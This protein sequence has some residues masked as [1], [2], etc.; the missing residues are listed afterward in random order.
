[1]AQ[2]G[3]I[4]FS[5]HRSIQEQGRAPLLLIHGAGGNRYHWPSQVRRL[6]GRRV[7]SLDLPGHA[8]SS[9]DPQS[10]IM[11]Y[12]QA[13]LAWQRDLGIPTMIPVGH[14]MGGAVALTMALEAPEKVGGLILVGT[15]AR[16]RVHPDLLDLVADPERLDQ[17][18][19]FVAGWAFS[20]HTSGELI[21]LARS[22]MQD[23]TPVALHADYNACNQVDLMERLQEI[24]TPTLVIC[25]EDDRLTPVKYS[26]YLAEQ[27]PDARLTLI[28]KAGHM[29]MLE[30]PEA[31]I[32]VIQSF[33]DQI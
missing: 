31:L 16:L 24:R 2:E 4:A 9:G 3:S 20:P 19:D 26:R 6:P 7:L 30:Q 13:V 5:D 18:L 12:A 28:P 14:S 10:T 27:I 33:L 25:G 32:D 22:H 23:V 21:R 11:A 17:A 8:R 15:G 1:M 29:V